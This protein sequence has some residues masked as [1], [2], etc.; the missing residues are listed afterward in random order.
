MMEELESHGYTVSPG[1]LYPT[2]NHLHE[3]GLLEK[4]EQ[5]VSGKVR[6]YY[7]IT[8]KGIDVLEE[9]KRQIIELANEVLEEEDI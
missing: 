7:T 3:E 6:K 4:Y 9:G 1:T 2:L 8:D 5:T